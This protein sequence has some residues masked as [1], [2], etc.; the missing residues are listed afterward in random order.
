MGTEKIV[1]RAVKPST[2]ASGALVVRT[3]SNLIRDHPSYDLH[4]ESNATH[5]SGQQPLYVLS[6]RGVCNQAS[7]MG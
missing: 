3:Q 2:S 4:R 5:P 7:D 6:Y 1:G